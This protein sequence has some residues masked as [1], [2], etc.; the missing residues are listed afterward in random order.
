MLQTLIDQI[1]Q[2][3][4]QQV[5]QVTAQRD[6]ARAGIQ[7]AYDTA[8]TNVGANYQNYQQ[9]AEAQ[10]RAIAQRLAD[11]LASQTSTND[12]MLASAQSMGRDT[13]ALQALGRANLDTLRNSN[14]YSQNLVDRMAQIAASGQNNTL[15]NLELT[16]QGASGTL[17]NRFT[18]LMGALMMNRDQ[19]KN[20]TRVSPC[21]CQYHTNQHTI[22]L[23]NLLSFCH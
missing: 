10:Q 23:I 14:S 3:Y 5:G 1:N 8:R 11:L 9:T 15:N 19:Q 4:D 2:Q 16:R 7:G 12:Q 13:T 20:V 22:D 18:D 21:L 6:Q 17:D